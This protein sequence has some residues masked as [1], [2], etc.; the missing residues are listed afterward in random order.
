MKPNNKKKCLGIS[1]VRVAVNGSYMLRLIQT[2]SAF[3]G[4]QAWR[5]GRD[6]QE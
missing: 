2:C 3:T 1:F 5:S 6:I 4:S